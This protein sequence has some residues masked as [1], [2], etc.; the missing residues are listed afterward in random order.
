MSH[1]T[2]AWKI[3]SMDSRVLLRVSGMKKMTMVIRA[4][5]APKKKYD[6]ERL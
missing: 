1:N 4:Q 6:P 2:Y 3:S 5:H